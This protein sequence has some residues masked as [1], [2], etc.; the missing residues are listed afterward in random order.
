[1]AQYWKVPAAERHPVPQ[2]P[3]RPW[4]GRCR[5]CPDQVI[6]EGTETRFGEALCGACA[7]ALDALAMP[8]IVPVD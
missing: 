8:H 3:Y 7:E 2:L 1:M 4:R 5:L 6:R